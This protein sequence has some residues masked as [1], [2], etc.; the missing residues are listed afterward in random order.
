VK[1][2]LNALW[3]VLSVSARAKDYT[4]Y[5]GDQFPY[6]AAA[7]ATD[8]SG[9]TYLTGGRGVTG[10]NPV[11]YDVFVTKLDS[12][13]SLVFTVTFSGKGSDFANAIAL[14]SSGNILVAGKTTSDN[15]P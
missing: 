11:L 6:Q 4:T 9:N 10:T 12:A 2:F 13:G 5:I 8:A 14:D 15:Y 7:V 1:A 3:L